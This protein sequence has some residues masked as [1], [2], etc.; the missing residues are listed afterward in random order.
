MASWLLLAVALGWLTH[1]CAGSL[2]LAV[3]VML[4]VLATSLY[5][6]SG[7]R[8]R[9]KIQLAT[10]DAPRSGILHGKVSVDATKVLSE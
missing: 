10:W 8:I 2:M 1:V 3:V 4:V 5:W 9:Q 6:S 7:M